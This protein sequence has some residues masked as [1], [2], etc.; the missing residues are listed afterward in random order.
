MQKSHNKNVLNRVGQG[1][2]KMD[3]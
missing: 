1:L 2:L 3:G